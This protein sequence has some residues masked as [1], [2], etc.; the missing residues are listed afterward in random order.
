MDLIP[1]II[2]VYGRTDIQRRTLARL[3]ACQS[4]DSGLGTTPAKNGPPCDMESVNAEHQR[5][6]RVKHLCHSSLNKT[7]VLDA[8]LE[9]DTQLPRPAG[10]S[11][12]NHF[13]HRLFASPFKKAN[14]SWVIAIDH[15]V[16]HLTNWTILHSKAFERA[17]QGY[18]FVG[19]MVGNYEAPR[20]G[21]HSIH[22]RRG[23][24]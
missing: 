1:P 13:R 24:P 9:A 17:P 16:R 3:T 11:R 18:D 20:S 10:T 21:W 7:V 6:L 2:A 15:D 5:Q 4:A 8:T 19:P 12:K 14:S 23:N 22:A